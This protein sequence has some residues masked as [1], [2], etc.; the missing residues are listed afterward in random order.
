MDYQNVAVAL[1]STIFGLLAGFALSELFNQIDYLDYKKQFNELN[2]HISAITKDNSRLRESIDKNNKT[3]TDLRLKN[4]EYADIIY[5][6]RK[7]TRELQKKYDFD[8]NSADDRL[9][10]PSSPLV[11]Q[12]QVTL[13]DW[14]RDSD[15]ESTD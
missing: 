2:N 11:R 5:R 14:S 4:K 13:D 15:S 8:Y 7:V 3:I 12:Y 6:Y 9:D 1:S 10:P